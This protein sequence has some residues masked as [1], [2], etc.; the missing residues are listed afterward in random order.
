MDNTDTS[1]LSLIREY[2]NLIDSALENTPQVP[3]CTRN[4]SAE[5]QTGLDCDKNLLEVLIIGASC[6]LVPDMTFRESSQ[7]I[8]QFG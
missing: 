6:L 3:S 8:H 2:G 1:A 7:L 4:Q 5:V